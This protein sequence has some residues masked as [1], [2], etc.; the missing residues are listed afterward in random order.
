MR[1]RR[2]ALVGIALVASGAGAFWLLT[3]PRTVAA[4]DLPA[5]TPDLANGELLFWAGGC[6]SCH[7]APQSEGDDALVLLGG[8]ALETAFGTFQPPNISS[9]PEHGIGAW[10][11]AEFVTAM[12]EGVA[13]D[14]SHLYPA[15]P[16][17][18]YRAM[19]VTDLL[20]L[21]A[22]LATLPASDNEPG[23][24]QVPFPFSIRRGIGLWKLLY[25]ESD[26]SADPAQSAAVSRGAY[27]VEA[28]AHCG[29][30]HTP[31][32]ALGG[33][34]RDRALAG[35]EMLDGIGYAPNL[36]P[37]EDGL[38]AWTAEDIAFAL[39]TGMNIEFDVLGGQM[40]DVQRNLAHL[41]QS[42]L[43]AIAEYLRSVPPLPDAE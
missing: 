9:D 14:G 8:A 23:E 37:H 19:S 13:P 35:A 36:T 4:E 26:F 25:L 40:A 20:D 7:A 43:L 32:T 30:C 24:H 21:R 5:H 1:F 11:A 39:E 27:L 18:S 6:A 22:F 41:P 16:Y 12:V 31:R 10:S 15:F 29:E 28:V 34:D 17:T 42:D 3:A 38:A 33:L 2:W